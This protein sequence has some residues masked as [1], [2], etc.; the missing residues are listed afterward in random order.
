MPKRKLPN[1]SV[2]PKK[3]S[4]KLPPTCK[5]VYCHNLGDCSMICDTNLSCKDSC[6]YAGF[7][8]EWPVSF[9][10]GK[11]EDKVAVVQVCVDE[12]CCYV[13][14]VSNMVK[15]PPMLKHLIESEN[16]IKVG[17]NIQGD[18]HKLAR[19]FGIDSE[20]AIKSS[21]DLSSLANSVLDKADNWSLA[22]LAK[23]LTGAEVFKHNKV[24]MSKW[25]YYPLSQ[26]Q[27]Q[28]AAID[29]FLSLQLYKE[30]ESLRGN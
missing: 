12:S 2:R 28:Y 18:L 29:A 11:A 25:D 17:V 4:F 9:E 20:K 26:T 10:K 24:R 8:A 21:V 6:L 7:D 13:F 3:S 30:L 19:N 5:V 16:F 23:Y 1:W 22:S 14:Q 27:I 15:F